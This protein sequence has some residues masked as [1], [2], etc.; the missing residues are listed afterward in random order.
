MATTV[1]SRFVAKSIAPSLTADD[2]D[3]SIR[4]YEGLGFAVEERWEDEGKLLGVMLRAGD[5][6]IG[7]SQDD[8]K[9]GRDRV[10]G[11]GMRIFISTTQDVDQLASAAKA[12][13]ITLDTDAHDTPWGSR[14]F[15][16]TDPDGFRVTVSSE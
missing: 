6:Q 14:A 2:L 16:L 10:K 3:R 13:G 7:L 8:W 9:K 5:V 4:F 1:N 15:D 11:Q 12:A